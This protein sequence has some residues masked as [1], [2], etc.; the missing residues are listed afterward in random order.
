MGHPESVGM[1]G[2]WGYGGERVWLAWGEFITLRVGGG[3]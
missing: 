2:F 3:G 1:T